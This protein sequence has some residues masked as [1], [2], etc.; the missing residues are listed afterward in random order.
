MTV[1]R[2]WL[3]PGA[4]AL[5][6]V[7]VAA[8][9]AMVTKDPAA[10]F[11]RLGI[12]LPWALDALLQAGEAL[13]GPAGWVAVAVVLALGLLPA[14]VD[15]GAARSWFA[16]GLVQAAVAL[17]LAFGTLALTSAVV[18]CMCHHPEP[19]PAWAAILPALAIGAP[20]L[21]LAQAGAWA[22]VA[23]VALR[24]PR[25]PLGEE[26]LRG[27][28]LAALPTPLLAAVALAVAYGEDAAAP[29]WLLLPAPVAIVGT[30]AL[31]TT[32]V[33]VALRLRRPTTTGA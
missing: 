19:P 28:V 20:L 24:L 1:H 21:G 8:L 15:P 7:G 10:E 12:A 14:R 27:L 30:A 9:V 13:R 22:R 11:A 5:A 6:W 31:A 16:L 32:C 33:A 25:A 3:L 4:W 18:A 23:W 17:P 26:V 2:R 29:T